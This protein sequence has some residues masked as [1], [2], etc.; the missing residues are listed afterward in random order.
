MMIRWW[1]GVSAVLD[2]SNPVAVNWFNKQLE[3]LTKDYGVDGFKFD[4]GDMC[5][6]PDNA[7]SKGNYSANKH[8][9]SY[10]QFGL[11]YPLNEYRACW[12][13]GNQPLAQRLH[14]K[15]HSWDD[16]QKLIPQMVLEGLSGYPFSCPDMIGGGLLST[17]QDNSKIN[18]ELVVRSAQCHAL[19]PM[20][21]FSV[22]PWRVLNENKFSG[23]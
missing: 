4:A 21:Q 12:K 14:D 23:C 18:Q 17:F 20:M 7:L 6:Y 1:N 9:E 19:M 5:Y 22:A 13:M 11:K 16:L 2:F 3:R 10:A 15:G 8:C